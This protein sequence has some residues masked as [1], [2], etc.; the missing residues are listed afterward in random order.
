M[1]IP[2]VLQPG[3]MRSALACH[4]AAKMLRI[5]ALVAAT[6]TVPA[7]QSQ[8]GLVM[9]EAVSQKMRGLIKEVERSGHSLIEHGNNKAA[10]QQYLL[11]GILKSTVEQ[12]ETAYAKQ[13]GSTGKILGNLENEAFDR[14]D[15][16]LDKVGDMQNKTVADVQDLI[17]RVQSVSN[18]LLSTLPLTKTEPIFIGIQTRDILSEFDQKPADLRL[19]AIGLDRA[20]G[21]K[22]PQVTFIGPDNKPETLPSRAISM[23]SERVD[24]ML[25]DHLKQSLR[26]ANTVCAPRKTFAIRVKYFFPENKPWWA[27]WR[28]PK[29]ESAERTFNALP[30]NQKFRATVAV[31]GIS[32]NEVVKEIEFSSTSP[33]TEW[34]CEERRTQNAYFHN[35]PEGAWVVSTGAEWNVLGGR[36]EN[37]GCDAPIASGRTVTGSCWVQGGNKD[38]WN[39]PGGGHGSVRVFGK[40]NFKAP[41]DTP[42]SNIPVQSG[43]LYNGPGQKSPMTLPA[44][45]G[46]R[47]TQVSV[48]IQRANNDKVCEATHDEVIVNLP[49]DKADQAVDT[50]RV[51]QISQRGEFQVTA[52]R[53]QIVIKRLLP[54]S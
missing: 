44:K 6:C 19:I 50:G 35:I 8:A 41:I 12:I 21:Y 38:F 22:L 46:S 29:E 10:Q 45:L 30:G 14:L 40:Y 32:T 47:Y 26:F 51:D 31:S 9:V 43:I 54:D 27:V 53:K 17:V 18:Q 36:W 23:F 25:P 2:Q 13:A 11:A 39:C 52:D 7:A 1:C 28:D 20:K 3:A 15:G 49:D 24:I 48:K 34:S 16:T 5:A 37:K 4:K 42:F 33:Q